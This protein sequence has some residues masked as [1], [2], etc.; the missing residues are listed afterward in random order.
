M[1][2][3]RMESQ[4]PHSVW[5]VAARA[6]FTLMPQQNDWFSLFSILRAED[7]G[8]FMSVGSLPS[9]LSN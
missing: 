4:V 8:P 3:W 6:E 1:L 5:L 9:M 2:F 7:L